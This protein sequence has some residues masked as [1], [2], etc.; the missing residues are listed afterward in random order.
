MWPKRTAGASGHPEAQ[1]GGAKP[2]RSNRS[3]SNCSN[4]NSTNSNST[5]PNRARPSRVRSAGTSQHANTRRNEQPI[6]RDLKALIGVLGL[7]P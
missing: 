5:S 1:E 4:S 2:A 7:N 6:G 3:N